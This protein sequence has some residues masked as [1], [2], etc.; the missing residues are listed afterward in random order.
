[1]NPILGN[2]QRVWLREK[3]KVNSGKTESSTCFSAVPALKRVPGTVR[4]LQN[5]HH[6]TSSLLLN[7]TAASMLLTVV[8]PLRSTFVTKILTVPNGED[9]VGAN[10]GGEE[11]RAPQ[12]RSVAYNG[13]F[14]RRK[15]R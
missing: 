5:V 13:N 12:A 6:A 10:R 1:L 4:K 15:G 8:L 9:G 3:N 14:H 2:S 7:L 11:T